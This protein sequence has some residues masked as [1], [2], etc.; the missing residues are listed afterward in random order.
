M[1]ETRGRSLGSNRPGLR[2]ERPL[3]GLPRW[4]RWRVRSAKRAQA[5]RRRPASLRFEQRPCG[6]APR[7]GVGPAAAIRHES[8]GR[9]RHVRWSRRWTRMQGRNGPSC[10]GIFRVPPWGGVLVRVSWAKHPGPP[11]HLGT[12]AHP[13]WSGVAS[14]AHAPESAHASPPSNRGAPVKLRQIKHLRN[15]R[16]P[17]HYRGQRSTGGARGDA[18]QG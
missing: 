15:N 4:Q 16:G 2:C 10:T 17:A 12:T 13:R 3:A 9:G 11:G 14:L 7:R 5:G 6:D 8:S 18:A 1:Q